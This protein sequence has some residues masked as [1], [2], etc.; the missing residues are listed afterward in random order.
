MSIRSR[1]ERLE[2]AR[3]EGRERARPA[4][5]SIWDVICGARDLED[6]DEA[7]R[8][9]LRQMLDASGAGHD[10]V[11]ERLAAAL[12]KSAVPLPPTGGPRPPP[13]GNGDAQ[14]GGRAAGS[15]GAGA[16]D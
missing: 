4:G 12:W 7:G 8:A 9:T 11:E 5:A 14:S 1:L 6:L 16:T 15:P 10:A 13:A 2:R 3:R